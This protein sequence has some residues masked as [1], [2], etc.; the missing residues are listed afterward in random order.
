MA[1]PVPVLQQSVR[2]GEQYT[3]RALNQKFAGVIKP[4]IYRGF[5]LAPG[6]DSSVQVVNGADGKSSVAVFERDDYSLTVI[7]TDGGYVDIPAHGDWFICLE[8]LY[9]LT[10]AQS[11]QR[12]VARETV[13]DYHI[14]LGKVLFDD[15]GVYIRD[16]GRMD[17]E[18]LTHMEVEQIKDKFRGEVLFA[19]A[20][21]DK[22]LLNAIDEMDCKVEEVVCILTDKLAG[23]VEK[24]EE[25]QAETRRL[26]ENAQTASGMHTD[27]ALCTHIMRNANRLMRLEMLHK[28]IECPDFVPVPLPDLPDLPDSPDV[29][30]KP[31]QPE[32]D[33]PSVDPETPDEPDYPANPEKPTCNC[34]CCRDK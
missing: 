30:E 1:N 34:C 27:I 3:S 8:C 24:A 25:V 5:K 10:P 14:I 21:A 32:P 9:A 4:G 16:E 23:T 6:D 29:P 11:Y 13:E 12:L 17:A 26:L 22:V 2:Y 31:A 28:G 33:N 19:L 7:M 18:I 15:T 20:E